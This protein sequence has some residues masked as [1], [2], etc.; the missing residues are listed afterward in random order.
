MR[1]KRGYPVYK[2]MS[3]LL[4]QSL[5][6]AKSSNAWGSSQPALGI[7]R[8]I[9]LSS[10]GEAVLPWDRHELRIHIL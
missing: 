1:K 5:G 4:N 9:V 8:S 7:R 6:T 2:S 3:M 10:S